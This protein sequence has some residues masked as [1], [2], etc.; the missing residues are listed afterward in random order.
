MKTEEARDKFPVNQFMLVDLGEWKC[1]V[2]FTFEIPEEI[3]ISTLANAQV[4]EMISMSV[5]YNIGYYEGWFRNKGLILAEIE[6]IL[7]HKGSYLKLADNFINFY[8]EKNI[9]V[10]V[11]YGVLVEIPNYDINEHKAEIDLKID[12]FKKTIFENN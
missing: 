9:I 10:R 1:K 7:P 8:A 3:S 6:I 2:I 12:N 11:L 5:F 4:Q